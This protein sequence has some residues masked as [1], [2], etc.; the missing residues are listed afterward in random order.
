MRNTKLLS[1]A[2]TQT[3]IAPVKY[4]NDEWNYQ[5]DNEEESEANVSTR[6]GEGK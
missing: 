4:W 6:D 2:V 3:E 5:R 1:V